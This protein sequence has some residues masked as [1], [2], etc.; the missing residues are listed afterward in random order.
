MQLSFVQR[1]HMPVQVL[2][3]GWSVLR[4]LLSCIQFV[5]LNHESSLSQFAKVFGVATSEGTV[6]L[7]L[8][9]RSEQF[10]AMLTVDSC[11]ELWT[12]QIER[13]G[14]RKCFS[15]HPSSSAIG[16]IFGR[17]SC[18]S[19]LFLRPIFMPSHPEIAEN[20]APSKAYA[21]ASFI[22]PFLSPSL[23]RPFHWFQ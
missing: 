20:L 21:I 5:T 12:L 7:S 10:V 11:T 16:R 13:K 23:S 1:C 19:E 2:Y 17:S 8:P 9:L 15:Y 6:D 3:S 4:I 18:N 14:K 22:F